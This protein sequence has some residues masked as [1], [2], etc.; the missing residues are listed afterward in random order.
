MTDDRQQEL[1][2]LYAFDLLEG[3]EKTAFE[4]EL[5]ADASLRALVAQLRETA[6]TLAHV[7]P[8][9]TPSPALKDR[10][11][12][13]VS[14]TPPPASDVRPPAPVLRPPSS[15][16]RSFLP[17]AIAA[18]LALVS[19]GVGQLYLSSRAQSALLQDQAAL[20]ELELRGARQL[21][22]AERLLAQRQLSDATEQLAN[23]E[24]QLAT[25]SGRLDALT[26]ASAETA[27]AFAA[28]RT[29][30]ADAN[31]E[32]GELREKLQAQG[33]LAQFKIATLASLAGNSP[34][35]LAV[36]V[37]NPTTQEGL[38]RVD[39]LPALATDQDY[40]LWV[41]DPAYPIPVDGGVFT[42]DPE[43][44]HAQIAFRPNKRVTN[45]TKF[46]VSL[47]RKGGVPK[48][49]GPILLLGD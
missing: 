20:A 14:A 32:I 18:C 40:Q 10:I 42:V 29:Q 21:L 36:A 13:K 8:A 45:A 4:A 1:A 38:L 27:R 22:E 39:K 7:A 15:V 31:T 24:R 28:L 9:A 33:D 43:T 34:E 6:T 30:L 35:A 41:I 2:A 16:F 12:Q 46:A 3:A 48:A 25:L 37:W 49:E 47:E 17:W 23:R 5:A 11:L 26:G 19:A 44:G